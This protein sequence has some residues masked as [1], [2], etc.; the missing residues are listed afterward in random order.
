MERLV[1]AGALV[2]VAL[3]VAWVLE[4]RRDDTPFSV[5]RGEVP[6]RVRPSDVGLADGPAI[7]V[8]TE[9]SCQSCQSAIRLVR[10]PAGAEFPVADVEYGQDTA[11]H[12]KFGIDTVPTTVVVDADG[13]VV[14]GWTGKVDPGEL[15]AAL[16]AVKGSA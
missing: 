16:A 9:A 13:V 5:R 7:V 6:T 2:V 3:I 12:Q 8:F 10:G 11:L 4:R 1:I 15:A 14:G